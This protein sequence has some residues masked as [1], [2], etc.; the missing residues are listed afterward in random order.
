MWPQI[1][2][3]GLVLTSL[4][5]IQERQPLMSETAWQIKC[6]AY[7]ASERQ[8]CEVVA[9]VSRADPYLSLVYRIDTERFVVIGH[10]PPVGVGLRIDTNKPFDFYLCTSQ[11]CLLRGPDARRLLQEMETGS[12]LVIEVARANGTREALQVPLAGFVLAHRQALARLG[13]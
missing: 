7:Q 1:A 5:L 8:D 6:S 2:K 11:A 12:R 9:D 3:V 10:P 4:I 13:R